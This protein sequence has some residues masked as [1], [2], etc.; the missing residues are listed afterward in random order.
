M[1]FIPPSELEHHSL[2]QAEQRA[3]FLTS[4]K[5]LTVLYIIGP[6]VQNVHYPSLII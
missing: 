4:I 6:E 1:H 2:T 3:N 5:Q